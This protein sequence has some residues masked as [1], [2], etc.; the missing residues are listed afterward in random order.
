MTNR[1]PP[2]RLTD[3][4][5]VAGL[6]DRDLVVIHPDPDALAA[7]VAARLVTAIL[8]AQALRG[9]AHVVLTGGTVGTA[10]L[11]AVLAEPAQAAVDWSRVDFWWSDERFEP[12]GSDLR[13]ETGARAA[14][15]DHLP[16]DPARVHPM[17][18]RG[19]E[20]GED[21]AAAAAGYA[22]ELAAAAPAGAA[23]PDFDVAMLGVGHD[24]HVA[25]LFPGFSAPPEG[26]TVIAVLDSPKPP[27]TRISFT[28]PVINSAAAVW[29][30]ADGDAKAAAVAAALNPAPG[31][32]P[33]PAGMVY[34]R[35]GTLALLDVAAAAQLARTRR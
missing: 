10:S 32:S 26:A 16:V 3:R 14:M 1:H 31:E 8:D 21:I 34:G 5:D 18:A 4:S 35:A 11:A 22:A 33:V 29:L 6:R 7:A 25:S 27:P 24:G 19:G 13:N 9:S 15:L 23:Y 12:T 2:Q 28:L 20:F 17:P 30:V